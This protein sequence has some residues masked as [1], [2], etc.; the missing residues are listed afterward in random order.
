MTFKLEYLI[1]FLLI[2]VGI[3]LAKVTSCNFIEEKPATPHVTVEYLDSVMTAN[4]LFWL[5]SNI[6][7]DY[8]DDSLMYDDGGE[9]YVPIPLDGV[10]SAFIQAEINY[11]DSVKLAKR[12][13]DI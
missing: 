10:D 1:P 5:E 2:V 4:H 9:E 7:E 11:M 13:V 6:D 12:P 8:Y 3:T